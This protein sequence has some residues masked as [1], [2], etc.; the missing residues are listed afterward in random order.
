MN[1]T[2]LPSIAYA[3]AIAAFLLFPVVAVAASVGLS[4]T[5]M[6]SIF[7]AD[8]A[9]TAGPFRVP[10]PADPARLPRLAQADCRAAA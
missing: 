9:R 3:A 7:I 5:G 10:A 1:T 2:I 4:I 8:Y 6:L